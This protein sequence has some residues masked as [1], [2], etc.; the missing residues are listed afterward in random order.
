MSNCDCSTRATVRQFDRAKAEAE[1]RAYRQNGPGVT[2]RH[3]A[4]ALRAAGATGTLL[5][6]GSGMGALTLEL[7]TSGV[8]TATCVDLAAGSIAVAREEAE[9]RGFAERITWREGD[10]VEVAESVAPADLV[11]LDKVVCCY[12]SYR[13]LLGKA[14]E[15]S[16]RWLALSFPRDRWYIRVGLW[17]ENTWRRLIGNDFRA[18]VHPIEAIDALLRE[19]GLVA[20]ATRITLFWQM[21]IYAR[22]PGRSAP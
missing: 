7:L 3:L 11:T 1:L 9:R 2:T 14:A 17:F 18:F 21:T 8:T 10:F 19:A 13:E 20:K 22:A 12:P 5:D 4:A 6:I 15:H 16:R